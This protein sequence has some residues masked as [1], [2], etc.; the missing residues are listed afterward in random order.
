[1][2]ISA[3]ISFFILVSACRENISVDS[4]YLGVIG[5]KKDVMLYLKSNDETLTGYYHDYCDS[6][7]KMLV[8]GSLSSDGQ[9][10]M[11]DVS[12]FGNTKWV[13]RLDEN[14]TLVGQRIDLKSNKTENFIFSS[15]KTALRIKCPPTGPPTVL[16][17]VPSKKYINLK[18][19]NLDDLREKIDARTTAFMRKGGYSPTNL[20]F[21]PSTLSFRC[22][23]VPDDNAI[24]AKIGLFYGPR[25]MGY[26][27]SCT[28]VVNKNPGS[29]V[30]FRDDDAS[31]FYELIAIP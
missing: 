28:N 19:R 11:S 29:Q 23:L 7:N 27:E 3:L 22:T 21:D 5:E 1:V 18:G 24:F 17:D 25:S 13:G 4:M 12:A 26:C 20:F 15:V 2:Q 31:F 30:L 16:T 6:L 14:N 10:E 8:T 9:F